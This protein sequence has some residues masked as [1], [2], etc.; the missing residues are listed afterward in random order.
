MNRLKELRKEKGITQQELADKIGV[1]KLSVSNWENGKHDIK[2]DKAQTL[3][4]YFGVSV[5]NLLGFIHT[6]NEDAIIANKKELQE[7]QEILDIG[8][9]I[10]KLYLRD[11]TLD[12]FENM[13]HEQMKFK[14]VNTI[15]ENGLFSSVNSEYIVHERIKHI[16]YLLGIAGREFEELI[17][18]WS[19]IGY[20]E[21]MNILNHLRLAI[22]KQK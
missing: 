19:L 15:D 17:L 2:S 6:D 14:T 11:K 1:T 16:Y 8:R 18:S 9:E 7:E 4:D 12:E 5:G 13:I 10:A 20:D 21:Q 3:A 22:D